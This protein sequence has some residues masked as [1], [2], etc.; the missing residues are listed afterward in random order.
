MMSFTTKDKKDPPNKKHLMAAVFEEVKER[1]EDPKPGQAHQV[2][3]KQIAA[4]ANTTEYLA[5]K[6]LKLPEG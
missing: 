2:T 6:V 4:R 1:I 5:K 3:W